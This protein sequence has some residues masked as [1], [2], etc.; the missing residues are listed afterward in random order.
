[1]NTLI[2][3]LSVNTI[4]KSKINHFNI[5]TVNSNIKIN[6]FNIETVNSNVEIVYFE[7]KTVNSFIEI[8]CFKNEIAYL[9]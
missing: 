5:K 9:P 4:F 2:K 8:D 6:Y 7:F 1:M 3:P